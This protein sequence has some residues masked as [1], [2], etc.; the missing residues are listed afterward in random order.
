MTVGARH[1]ARTRRLINSPM[2]S[3]WS[4]SVVRIQLNDLMKF[5]LD[6]DF[7]CHISEAELT[8]NKLLLAYEG[9]LGNLVD[10]QP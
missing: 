4:N 9:S 8:P 3:I 5:K 2:V 6:G 10:Y 1:G 7:S